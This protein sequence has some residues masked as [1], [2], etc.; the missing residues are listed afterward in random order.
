MEIAPQLR[1]EEQPESTARPLLHSAELSQT[2]T[3]ARLGI[4]RSPRRGVLLE[5]LHDS[6]YLKINI[7]QV[8]IMCEQ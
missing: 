4:S 5:F 6:E 7:L 8:M 2:C 3:G 1:P